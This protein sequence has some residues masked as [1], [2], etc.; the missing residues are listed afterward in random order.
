MGYSLGQAAKA[1][2]RSKTTIHR[3]IKSGKLSASWTEDG[4]WSI[5]PADLSRLTRNGERCRSD[6][7]IR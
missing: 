3:A 6:G 5:D 2:G 7:T 1:A 4:G